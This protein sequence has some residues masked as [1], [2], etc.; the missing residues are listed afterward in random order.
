[1]SHYEIWVYVQL[2][3]GIIQEAKWGGQGR[4]WL[5]C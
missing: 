1:M 2:K 3:D 5:L 4:K